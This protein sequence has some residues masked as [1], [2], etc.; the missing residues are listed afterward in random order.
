MTLD[1]DAPGGKSTLM[2]THTAIS[3]LAS[4]FL[5][6]SLAAGEPAELAAAK[7]AIAAFAETLKAELTKAMQAGGPLNAI[8][9]CSERAP[10][11]AASVSLEKGMNLSRVSLRNR[12]P[13]NVPTEWQTTV[14]QEFEARLAAGETAPDLSWHQTVDTNG[15]QEFRFMK[16]I[17]TGS[18]CL[19][20]HGEAIAPPV[21]A[22]INELYPAD[23]A[24]GFRE[25]DLRGAF[26]VTKALQP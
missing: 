22:K 6:G 5:S 4:V 25:G 3:C 11:I 10:A 18:L 20:C 8:E 15:N 12:N 2:K 9:V 24:T 26:V 13:E 23:K 21:A 7:G 16:A 17:P 19:T 1:H 14:L